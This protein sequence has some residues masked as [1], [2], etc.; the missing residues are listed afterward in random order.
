MNRKDFVLA[1]LLQ[2]TDTELEDYKRW[3]RL[4]S[5]I[6]QKPAYSASNVLDWINLDKFNA[7]LCQEEKNTL[8]RSSHAD[9][10]IIEIS[11][12][13]S[14]SSP[15]LP[16]IFPSTSMRNLFCTTSLI[17]APQI[18]L[19]I[20][21]EPPVAS[22]SIPSRPQKGGQ[23]RIS[24]TEKVDRVVELSAVPDRWEVPEVDTAY[25]LDFS[26]DNRA[27]G[28]TRTGKPKGLDAFLKSE[29]Q[30]SWGKGTDGSTTRDTNL[31]LLGDIPSR[32]STH[33]CNGG[34]KCE[35]FDRKLLLNY[36]R[37]DEEDMTHTQEI[38]ARELIQNQT[39][40][41]SPVCRA[42]SFFRVVQ[43]YKERGCPKTGWNGIPLLKNRRDGPS[44]DGKLTFVGCTKWVNGEKW[45]HHFA[46][47]PADVDFFLIY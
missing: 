27:K 31:K 41:G 47:I 16:V 2:S 12:S 8:E 26:K 1:T 10:D 13:E 44:K 3:I 46:A 38:F 24:R 28:E 7:Y 33:Q 5:E 29:D 14:E 17:S 25:I 40:S 11:D 30:D 32:R 23:I 18:K 35:Y 34:R 19:K 9:P 20:K 15:Q 4:P 22:R 6:A 39:D 36:Q 42:A 45:K 37:T 21:Q 43:R